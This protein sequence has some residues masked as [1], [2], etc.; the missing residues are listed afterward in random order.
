MSG[1][2]NKLSKFWQELKRRR[3][4]HV[5]IVYATASFV[6]IELVG[7]VYE[8]LNLPDWTPALTLVI[9]A[10]GFPL[11]IIFSWIFDVTPE[12]IEKTKPFKEAIEEGETVRSNSWRIASYVSFAVIVAL[13]VLNILPRTKQSEKKELLEKAIAVLPFINDSPDEEKMYFINGTMEAIHDNLCKI[14]DIRVVSRTSVEQY[15]NNLKPVQE[16]AGEM[17]VSYVLEGS[18]LKDEENI[19][20]NIYLIDALHDRQIWS[21]TYVRKSSEIF[22]LQSEIAQLVASEIQALVSPREKELIDKEPTSSLTSYDLY[23]QGRELQLHNL[24]G[25]KRLEVAATV[26]SL[27]RRALEYDSTF[28]RAYVG[29]AEIC[30]SKYSWDPYLFE[31][32]IDSVLIYV[33]LALSY[34][35]QLADAYIVKGYYYRTISETDLA[36]REWEKAISLSPNAAEPYKA[37]GWLYN[38]IGDYVK[39][40]ESFV[41]ASSLNRGPELP[42]ILYGLGFELTS[43]GFYTESVE[44]YHEKLKLDSDS[45][46]YY[47]CI[48]YAEFCAGHYDKA[49]ETGQIAISRN[50][51][52]PDAWNFVGGSYL[53]LKQYEEALYYLKR[54]AEILDSMGQMNFYSIPPLAFAYMK[55]G[56]TEKSGFYVNEQIT[57]SREWIRRRVSGYEGNYMRL[58]QVY[59]ISGDIENAMENLSLC[60]KFGGSSV[61]DMNL[62]DS[63][64]LEN[65]RDEPGFLQIIN[66]IEA[67]YQAEHER[68]RQWLEENDML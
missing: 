68:V 13:I 50:P 46:D 21:D 54:F 6:I 19:R 5:I 34:D 39:S 60:K 16:I 56:D 57:M 37:M 8:T 4:V 40:I 63:P 62:R 29:L 42:S 64:L 15:R 9:L 55:N 7:N 1:N 67:K 22:S 66:E 2:P 33:N 44:Q 65:I 10:I 23:Q 45:S 25:P 52:N 26:E 53:E 28:A 30:H 61:H 18:G 24:R 14:G 58:A 27:Y 35:D 11:A 51:Q 20:L 31:P 12:G 3:V 49:I 32:M 59:A 41:K 36:I 43:I 38:S 48:C 47:R 17:K